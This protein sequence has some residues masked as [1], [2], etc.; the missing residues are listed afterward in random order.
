MSLREKCG[1]IGVSSLS[2]STEVPASLFNGLMALQH[3]GQESA[4]IAVAVGGAIKAKVGMGLVSG[5]F[6]AEGIEALSAG[7]GIGHVRYSTAGTSSIENAQPFILEHEGIRLAI[8]FN[9]NI[10]NYDELKRE[11]RELHHSPFTCSADTEVVAR[12]LA[13][14]LS[15]RGSRHPEDYFSS[16]GAVMQKLE[17]AYAIA[18]LFSDGTLLAARDPQGYKP[19]S[20]GRR[21]TL[22]GDTVYLASESCAFNALEAQFDRDILPGE[23]IVVRGTDVKSKVVVEG[24]RA[25]CMFEWVYFSRVDSVLNGRSV[26]EVRESLGRELAELYKVPLDVV[27]PVPDS[28]RSAAR[29]FYKQSGV[30]L[31][32]GL[33]KNRYVFRTF[34]MPSES[35]RRSS[36]G[37]KLSVVTP[38]V[39][40][41]RIALVDD[42]IVRGNTT[43]KIVR[44]LKSHGAKEVHVFSSCPPIVSPCYMGIDFPTYRELVAYDRN[45]SQISAEIGADG[46]HYM[47]V[48]ALVRSIGL[49]KE[50]LCLGCLTGAYPTE[51]INGYARERRKEERRGFNI[52]VLASGRGSNLQ[53]IIDAVERKYLN[54]SIAVVVSDKQN[55]PALQRA[56]THAIEALHVDPKAF[57]DRA[58]YERRIL[59]ILSA[60]NVDLVV[61]A[62]YMRI[63]GPTLLEAFPEAVINIH[64]TLLPKFRGCMGSACHQ[65]VLDS[66]DAESGCTVHI[67]TPE[68]DGGPVIG[69]AR[70]PVKPGDTAESLAE[71]ILAEEHRLLPEVI[72]VISEGKKGC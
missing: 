67:V 26:Y 46:V 3:R 21:K 16:M 19:F 66:G 34:I 63:V 14:E 52:A 4:G 5:V 60:R 23:V 64:P 49:P 25:H 53:S 69:Q 38:V 27:V 54:V 45:L 31:D 35:S 9:G 72:K 42:S 2:A 59:E 57:K 30:P 70:V 24:R 62:G 12:M 50:D 1:V 7:V 15:G 22:V 6:D 20:I 51:R 56:A 29:G 10:V 32:E 11:M 47:T 44:L 48:D 43:R 40:G 33:I 61:L 65:A 39:K 55:A 13:M 58:E 41:R 8:S 18:I 71:R 17:G 36:I 37:L 28:G 68:V